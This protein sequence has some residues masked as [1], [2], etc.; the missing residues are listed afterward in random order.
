MTMRD[1]EYDRFGPWIIEISEADPPPPLFQPY[2]T[3]EET[4]LLSI[5]IPR[6]IERRAARPGMNLYD[7]MITLYQEDMVILERV[8]NDVE[9]EVLF[10]R[11]IQYIRCG[12]HLLHGNLYLST[13]GRSYD[14]P[15]N[16]VSS[17]IMQRMINL[18][19]RGY[20]ADARP[21]PTIDVFDIPEDDFSFYFTGLLEKQ[22]IHHPEF[23]LLAAQTETPIRSYETGTFRK[24]LY[25]IIDKRLL[26]SLH[27]SDGREFK[28]ITRGKTYK[29]KG[30]VKILYDQ[31][32][33]T[34]LSAKSSASLGRQIPRMRPL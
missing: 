7:Y 29:Y 19:R 30:Q 23:Q 27:L 16:T 14:L 26:E 11:D 33:S 25:N 34:Y 5:K 4:P 28:I 10:Y 24:L 1:A 18:I 21:S 22:K 3:R 32:A 20:A 2:L 15:F 13:T 8:G 9:S 6:K 12:E 17:A 31:I